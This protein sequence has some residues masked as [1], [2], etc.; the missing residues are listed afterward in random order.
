MLAK[1][2]VIAPFSW[3]WMTWRTAALYGT[4]R[5]NRDILPEFR[6]GARSRDRDGL[7]LRKSP[8]ALLIDDVS[9]L[10]FSWWRPAEFCG[11]RRVL[12]LL[13]EAQLPARQKLR[14][15]WLR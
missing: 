1:G 10:N 4:P 12:V 8:P 14:R 9:A 2:K 15:E 6:D 13:P 5:R 7:L 3:S 11:R